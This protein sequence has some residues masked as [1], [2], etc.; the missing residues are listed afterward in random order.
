MPHS[1]P[2][3]FS[4]RFYKTRKEIFVPYVH[5]SALPSHYLKLPVRTFFHQWKLDERVKKE[6]RRGVGMA[7]D[8]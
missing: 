8:K 5:C 2:S 3:L 6:R 1:S 4:F 7:V